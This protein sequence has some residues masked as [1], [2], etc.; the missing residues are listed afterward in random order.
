M[1]TAAR[2]PVPPKAPTTLDP[3]STVASHALLTGPHRITVRARAVLHPYAR[4]MAGG[5]PVDIGE[6]CIIWEK[7]LVGCGDSK[8]TEGEEEDARGV[9]LGPNVVIET[10]AVVE[11]REV[12]E[13]SMIESF[14]RV[15][16]GARIGKYCKI[17]SYANIPAHTE[18]P[19][20]TVVDGRNF[21]RKDKTMANQPLVREIRAANHAKQVKGL[22]ALIPSNLV[23]WQ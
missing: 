2:R 13:G 19:D 8:I 12:G 16:V 18:L 10:G 3:A 22:Q 11:A 20:Y 4:I 23:K 5:G 7:A 9:R 14:A 21:R 17:L 1:A 6:G 15:G